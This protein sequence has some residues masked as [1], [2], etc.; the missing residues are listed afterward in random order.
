MNV[1]RRVKRNVRN[2]FWGLF[3]IAIAVVMILSQL[4]YLGGIGFGTIV[5]AAVSVCIFIDGI[6]K[7]SFP[8][9]LFPIAMIIII[10]DDT[11]G[12]EAITPWPILGAALLLSIGL[13]MIF[14][15]KHKINVN[16]DRDDETRRYRGNSNFIFKDDEEEDVFDD[17]QETS[18]EDADKGLVSAHVR[19][20]GSV[21]YVDLKN[22]KYADLTCEYG[23]LEVY[24]NQAELDGDTARISLHGKCGNVELYVPYEW[25]IINNLDCYLGNIDI[26]GKSNGDGTKKVYLEGSY[27]LGNVEVIRKA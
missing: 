23:N 10:F 22:F 21:K 17:Y 20:G 27:K 6:I 16:I 12:L 25:T 14:Q 18:S 3:F 13:G 1:N 5:L 15:K 24:F 7:F 4:G 9:I 2:S 19:L 11:L 26:S 8:L